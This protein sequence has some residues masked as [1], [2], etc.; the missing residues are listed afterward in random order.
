MSIEAGGMNS[1][2]PI[3]V[4]ARLGIPVVD[5]DGMGRAFPE[6]QQTV[7]TAYVS[8]PAPSLCR[9]ARQPPFDEYHQQQMGGDFAR[10]CVMHMGATC[11]IA[12][13]SA[14]VRQLK[15]AAIHGT[16]TLAEEIGK[17]VRTA[18]M[19]EKNP[20]DALRKAVGGF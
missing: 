11:V 10:S 9:R 4:G 13:Y 3:Y 17:T 7:L 14:T 16:I 2:R 19:N 15:Q 6:I 8:T 5:G 18:R 20:V 1:I 12:L